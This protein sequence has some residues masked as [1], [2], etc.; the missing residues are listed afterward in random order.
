MTASRSSS[1]DEEGMQAVDM[2]TKEV[3][4][5]VVRWQEKLSA[6]GSAS[7]FM[8]MLEGVSQ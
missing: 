2:V 4:W 8:T 5:R 1:T 6:I 3:V 7:D